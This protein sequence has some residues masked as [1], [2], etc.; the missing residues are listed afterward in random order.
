MPI[1]GSA[2]LSRLG[3]V[4]RGG[5]PSGREDFLSV[6]RAKHEAVVVSGELDLNG[7]QPVPSRNS[8]RSTSPG[9]VC[10]HLPHHIGTLILYSRRTQL[11]KIL[12]IEGL[13]ILWAEV[14][15]VDGQPVRN[16]VAAYT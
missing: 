13:D 16:I 5:A 8:P 3:L 4:A 15:R 12:L 11:L 9:F 10:Y 6:I 1:R 2:T 14:D 7:T